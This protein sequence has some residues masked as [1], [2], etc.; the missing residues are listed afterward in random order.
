M[1][2]RLIL[3]SLLCVVLSN[4]PQSA[5]VSLI[6]QKHKGKSQFLLPFSLSLSLL[7]LLQ[8][9]LCFRVAQ[10]V[11]DAQ[12]SGRQEYLKAGGASEAEP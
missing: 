6:D 7:S 8:V 11:I 12:R 9:A 4:L 1:Y 5:W 10:H 3:L 2:S